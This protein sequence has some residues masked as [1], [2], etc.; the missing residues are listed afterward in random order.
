MKQKNRQ[1]LEQ[2]TGKALGEQDYHDITTAVQNMLI[3]HGISLKD[4]ENPGVGPQ[5]EGL[6]RML[7][8]EK[9]GSKHFYRLLR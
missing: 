2:E 3:V 5:P 7:S 8:W 6:T 4:V 1:E 9:K